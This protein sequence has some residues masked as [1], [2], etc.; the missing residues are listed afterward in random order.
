MNV[1]DDST[2]KVT[3]ETRRRHDMTRFE[4]TEMHLFDPNATEERTL[5]GED[6][7]AY[8]RRDVNGYLEDRL[9]GSS[10]G[11]VCE[12]CKARAVPFALNLIQDMEAEGFLDEAEE[13][14]RLADTLLRE[15]GLAP[16][17][18]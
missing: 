7:S 5:G 15:T 1:H 18:G 6:T 11:T 9:H 4:I 17:L 13:Y 12:A 8:D 16:S 14:R 2:M 10:V 3:P